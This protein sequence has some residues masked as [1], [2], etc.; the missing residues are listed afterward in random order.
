MKRLTPKTALSRSTGSQ[1]LRFVGLSAYRVLRY[2][3]GSPS[4][5]MTG[6]PLRQLV[7]T[8]S[9]PQRL[10]RTDVLH[11]LRSCRSRNTSLGIT[12]AILYADNALLQVLEGPPG[13]VE[14]V[15]ARIGRDPRHEWIMP[16]MDAEIE[17]RAFP[18]WPM[19]LLRIG[20]VPEDAEPP[21]RAVLE[22]AE[23]GAERVWSV[24]RAFRYLSLARRMRGVF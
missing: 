13:A 18:D 19:G 9:T 15:Y 7:Y 3:T 24:L 22:V 17:A 23:T 20:D 21:V 12:G 4:D 11:L 2:W 1:G 5:D 14:D 8:S 10:S 6:T 16:V